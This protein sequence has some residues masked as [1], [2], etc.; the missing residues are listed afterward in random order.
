M[1]SSSAPCVI[2]LFCFMLTSIDIFCDKCCQEVLQ[3]PPQGKGVLILTGYMTQRSEP[4]LLLQ[5]AI[6]DTTYNESVHHQLARRL[7]LLILE[8]SQRFGGRV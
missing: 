3:Y 5:S 6:R 4:S 7:K 1:V 2:A 8:I